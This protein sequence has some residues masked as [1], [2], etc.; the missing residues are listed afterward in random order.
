MNKLDT[1]IGF[2]LSKEWWFTLRG[3]KLKMKMMGSICAVSAL[4]LT[5][6]IN[7]VHSYVIRF[8]LIEKCLPPVITSDYLQRTYSLYWK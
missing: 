5:A 8:I 6:L 1:G 3:V 4:I 2:G 7:A